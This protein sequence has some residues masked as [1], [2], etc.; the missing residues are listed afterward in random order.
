MSKIYEALERVKE[1]KVATRVLDLALL[2]DRRESESSELPVLVNSDSHLAECF[3]FL[4]SR[5]MRPAVGRPP[6]SL[7]ISSALA[8]EGKTFIAS[9]LACSI[10]QSMDEH[11]LLIDAD[12]RS[13]NIHDLFNI[14]P[15]KEGLSEFL[16]YGTTLSVLLRK[17]AYDKLTI[18]SA[19]HSTKKPAELLSSEKMR[20]LIREVG[21]RYSDRLAI[22]DGPPLELAPESSVVANEVDAVILVVRHGKTPRE[23][24]KAAASKVKREKLIG[25]IYNGY[26]G[27][28]LV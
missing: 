11:V 2:P 7:L 9:N 19:G 14:H 16:A 12:L 20:T 1:E 23:A 28:V 22:I 3:R 27:K 26:D 21:E 15:S 25:I 8:D 6:R 10:S 5:I 17:T 4:R 13:P 24:V 18:L